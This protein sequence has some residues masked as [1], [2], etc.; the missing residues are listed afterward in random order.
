M[1][2][3]LEKFFFRGSKSVVLEKD[4]EAELKMNEF[5]DDLFTDIL[6]YCNDY[7]ATSRHI[8]RDYAFVPAFLDL[9]KTRDE[10]KSVIENNASTKGYV[11]VYLTSDRVLNWAIDNKKNRI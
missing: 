2:E 1:F 8:K 10:L 9:K 11:N 3:K 7:P 6:T 4:S 5:V